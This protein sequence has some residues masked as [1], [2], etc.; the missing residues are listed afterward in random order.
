MIFREKIFNELTRLWHDEKGLTTVEY[1]VAGAL[2][3]ASLV[4]AFATLGDGVGASINAMCKVVK[5]DGTDC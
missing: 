5:N 3:A 1:A 4:G 2:V